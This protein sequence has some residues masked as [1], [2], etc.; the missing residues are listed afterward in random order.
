M[1]FKDYL[2]YL[3]NMGENP[4]EAA[5]TRQQRSLERVGEEHF[6]EIALFFPS[7]EEA[8][9]LLPTNYW[10]GDDLTVCELPLK[11]HQFTLLNFDSPLPS[12]PFDELHW[13]CTDQT[14][15]TCL[16]WLRKAARLIHIHFVGTPATAGIF[17]EVRI[18]HWQRRQ[19]IFD[20]WRS[21]YRAR[22]NLSS[23]GL[24]WGSHPGK[25][26]L[27][28]IGRYTCA[29]GYTPNRALLHLKNRIRLTKPLVAQEAILVIESSPILSVGEFTCIM[30]LMGSLLECDIA[31]VLHLSEEHERCHLRLLTFTPGYELGL[32]KV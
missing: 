5:V 13:L 3:L 24:N 28:V 1:Q 16:E 12:K 29:Y 30:D 8:T 11:H 27:P 25:S 14:N 31:P 6:H 4:E 23:F 10:T 22:D 21:L 32:P 9:H 15:T 17:A 19:D 26:S 2:Y 20:F 18:Y 7:R